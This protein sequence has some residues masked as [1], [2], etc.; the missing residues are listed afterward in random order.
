MR[1][2]DF[3]TVLYANARV[4]KEAFDTMTRSTP[5]VEKFVLLID[6]SPAPKMTGTRAASARELGI[7]SGFKKYVRATV[8]NGSVARSVMAN[9]TL[10]NPR[11]RFNDSIPVV[12][13]KAS[14]QTP[15][16]HLLG[17]GRMGH[18]KIL[19]MMMLVRVAII[20]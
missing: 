8:I 3:F 15:R 16:S 12:K 14:S 13:T 20:N 5:I 7:S 17:S 10:I 2:L 18:P 9:D 6:D 4:A 19:D 11:D 1:P